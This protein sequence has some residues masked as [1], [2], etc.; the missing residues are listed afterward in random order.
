MGHNERRRGWP[1]ARRKAEGAPS[2]SSSD[3]ECSC[4][5]GGTRRRL[6]FQLR[7]GPVGKVR[8]PASGYYP[9]ASPCREDHMFP[10]PCGLERPD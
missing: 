7:D 3:S 1:V 5:T 10:G 9:D 6:L 2:T 8:P 4:G